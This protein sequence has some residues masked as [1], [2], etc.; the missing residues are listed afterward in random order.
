MGGGDVD[1]GG[2]DVDTDDVVTG[3]DEFARE[4]SPAASEFD[5]EALFDTALTE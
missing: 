3:V 4:N 1:H 5:D 2:R